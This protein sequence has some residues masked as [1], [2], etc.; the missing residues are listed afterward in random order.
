[1][2]YLVIGHDGTDNE[3]LDR[4]LA[5]R[6]AHIKMG[7]RLRAEGKHL[8]GAALLDDSE[9]MVGSVLLVDFEGRSELDAWLAEEPY[10][11]GK[12]WERVEVIRCQVGPSFQSVL[13][14]AR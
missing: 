5:A 2:Q 9:K 1:M 12:V 11:V 14:R 4:R 7:D 6:A 13:E 3:A 8:L 10:V